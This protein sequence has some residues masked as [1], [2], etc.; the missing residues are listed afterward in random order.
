MASSQGSLMLS[1]PYEV[2]H[3]LSCGV[4]MVHIIQTQTSVLWLYQSPLNVGTSH[5][6]PTFYF[7][8]VSSIYIFKDPSSALGGTWNA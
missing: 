6:W 2:R 4:Q 7:M 3:T 8:H 1:P 5:H